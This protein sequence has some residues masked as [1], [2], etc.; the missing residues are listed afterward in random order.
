VRSEVPLIV[1]VFWKNSVTEDILEAG[2]FVSDYVIR[3][4]FLVAVNVNVIILWDVSLSTLL[5]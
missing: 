1:P 5:P 2:I 3:L 4:E